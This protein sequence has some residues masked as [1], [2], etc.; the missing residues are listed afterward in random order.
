VAERR[1]RPSG[2][3]AR[4]TVSIA[5]ILVIAIGVTFLVIYRGTGST[6]RSS[7]DRELREEIGAFASQG[8]GRASGADAHPEAPRRSHR[9]Q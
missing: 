4:L 2:L 9:H 7:V 5:A 1:L 6:L 8:L 3:R